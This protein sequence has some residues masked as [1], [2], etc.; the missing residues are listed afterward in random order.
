MQ[1][2]C[3]VKTEEQI[4]NTLDENG[5]CSNVSMAESMYDHCGK[6]YVARPRLNGVDGRWRLYDKKNRPLCSEL[7]L[8]WT[9]VSEWLDFKTAVDENDLTKILEE[10]YEK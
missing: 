3:K 7:G 9:W 10:G 8:P 5:C 6:V 4:K 1:T 2:L